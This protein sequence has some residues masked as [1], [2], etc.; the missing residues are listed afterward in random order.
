MFVW[1]LNIVAN[2]EEIDASFSY[3]FSFLPINEQDVINRYR[4]KKDAIASLAGQIMSRAALFDNDINL[5]LIFSRTDKGRPFA[6]HTN[7]AIQ[8][9][10]F[11]ISHHGDFVSIICGNNG[12]VGIDITKIEIDTPLTDFLPAFRDKLSDYEMNWILNGCIER[13]MYVRFFVLW[14]LKESVVKAL[15]I[16]IANELPTFRFHSHHNENSLM[17]IW[18]TDHLSVSVLI[19]GEI[20]TDWS[21]Y[22]DWLDADHLFATAINGAQQTIQDIRTVTWENVILKL[23]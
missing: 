3:C 13:E 6:H 20:Q 23:R 17:K 7:D 19:A 15:G 12:R 18:E 2:W 16:G 22:V 21:F 1:H 8:I 4:I 10:D 11:N 9:P 14:A 5:Q